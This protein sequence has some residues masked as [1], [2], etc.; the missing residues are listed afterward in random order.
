MSETY[1]CDCGHTV[2]TSS[3]E[4]PESINW[5]DG[6]ICILIKEEKEVKNGQTKIS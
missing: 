6:H 2:H 3:K 1:R 4:P 5:S